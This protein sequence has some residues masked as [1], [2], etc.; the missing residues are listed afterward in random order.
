MTNERDPAQDWIPSSRYSEWPGCRQC[1]HFRGT[2][3]NAYPARIP[4]PFVS[5]QTDHMVPRPGDQG[6]Q[7]EPK[8]KSA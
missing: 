8:A 5:G 6:I 1:A 4:L 2:H 3:C 7:F